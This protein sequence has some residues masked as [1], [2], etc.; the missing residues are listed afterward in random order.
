LND[1]TLKNEEQKIEDEN[2]R[3]ELFDFTEQENSNK[4]E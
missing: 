3:N 4:N 2:I 1:Q